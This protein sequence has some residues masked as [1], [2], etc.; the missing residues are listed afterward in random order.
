MA[1][2]MG[3]GEVQVMVMSTLYANDEKVLELGWSKVEAAPKQSWSVIRQEPPQRQLRSREQLSISVGLS[4]AVRLSSSSSPFILIC[5]LL[6]LHLLTLSPI[7]LNLDDV[8]SD[9]SL[10]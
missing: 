6:L 5:I 4:V 10:S 9:L 2:R 8:C 1:M 7:P 3:D